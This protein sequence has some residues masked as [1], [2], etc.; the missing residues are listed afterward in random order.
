MNLA[1]GEVKDVLIKLTIPMIFGMLGLVIF[2]LVDSLYISNYSLTQLAAMAFTLPVVLIINSLIL[3]IG[4]GTT[5]AVSRAKGSGKH[6]L[7][8]RYASDSLVLGVLIA[9]VIIG[10]GLL[11][12][13]PLFTALGADSETLPYVIK[14]MRIWYLGVPFVVIPMIGNNSIR[15]LGDTKTPSI[16]MAVAATVNII[17]D[18]IFIFGIGPVPELG[19][20]GAAIA[21]VLSRFTTFVTALYVLGKREKVLSFKN[22]KLAEI[23]ES[24]KHVLYVGI[25][26]ALT[27]MI[28]P[29]ATAFITKLLSQYG[30]EII[31]GYSVAFRIEQVLLVIVA[32]LGVIM[33]PFIGQNLGSR[34]FDR[35]DDARKYMERFSLIFS[36]IFYVAIFFLARPLA[37]LFVLYTGDI[38]D[39]TTVI[40][41]ITTYLRIVPIAYGLQGIYLGTSTS[42][43]SMRKPFKAAAIG[44]VQ[45]FV[46]YVPL[47]YLGSSLFGYIG[48]FV[49]LAFAYVT[50]GIVSHF[51]FRHQVRLCKNKALTSEAS[52][53]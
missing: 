4:V 47:A 13:R 22:T 21:T 28:I 34:N 39:K 23:W 19:I 43:N 10:I 38:A 18:P 25:P 16:V 7:I 42:L 32:A 31:G 45:M 30:K 2:N 8:E 29:L 53:C 51:V 50:A 1:E 5:A 20:E 37:T 12:M 3:G 46:I 44:I 41:E 36:I 14:Y 24:W 17:L 35:I 15:S 11:T 40:D 26:T 49:A 33:G 27:R 48:V 9:I 52:D 6:H